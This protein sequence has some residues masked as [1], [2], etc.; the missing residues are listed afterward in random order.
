M[1][2]ADK[3]H[4]LTSKEMAQANQA[5]DAERM[6]DVV[7]ALARA[8]GFSIA[9]ATK[10]DPKGIDTM[11]EGATAYAHGEAVDKAKFARLFEGLAIPRPNTGSEK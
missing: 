6:G 5:K 2:F 3:L 10:G 8:L 4:S 9:I 7:E 1:G 11:I